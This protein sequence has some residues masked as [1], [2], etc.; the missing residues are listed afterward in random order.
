MSLWSVSSQPS[1][2]GPSRQLSLGE[3][4]PRGEA[5]GWRSLG[6]W[7]LGVEAHGALVLLGPSEEPQLKLFL[8]EAFPPKLQITSFV[9]TQN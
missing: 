1:A 5:R 9:G 4:R 8:R 2:D 3:Q 6:Q 7:Q